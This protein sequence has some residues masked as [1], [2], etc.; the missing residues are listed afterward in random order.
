MTE[1]TA[2]AETAAEQVKEVYVAVTNWPLLMAVA[3]VGIAVGIA[4][5]YG[6]AKISPSESEAE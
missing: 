1:T 5:V 2:A 4:L 6:A 3:L